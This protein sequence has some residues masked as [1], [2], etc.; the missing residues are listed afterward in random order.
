MWLSGALA[1]PF[2]APVVPGVR[3]EQEARAIAA[4]MAPE[5][6]GLAGACQVHLDGWTAQGP[7]LAT[8]MLGEL[9]ELLNGKDLPLKAPRA[10]RP[11]WSA[12]VNQV[13]NQDSGAQL[14]AVREDDALTVIG[15]AG[16]SIAIAHSFAPAGHDEAVGM[17]ARLGVSGGLDGRGWVVSTGGLDLTTKSAS[18]VTLEELPFE[19][20]GEPAA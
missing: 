14:I 8:A 18:V 12:V 4:S 13:L 7:T 15:G 11:W 5:A 17:L 6:T 16:E 19:A 1:R 9:Y 2:M 3:S 20:Y 10:V